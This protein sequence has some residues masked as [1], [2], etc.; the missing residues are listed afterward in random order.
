MH[1]LLLLVVLSSTGY[2][3][4]NV[5]ERA[6]DTSIRALR[7]AVREFVNDCGAPPTTE[8][9]LTAL[10]VDPGTPGWNGPYIPGAELHIL[11]DMWER[12]LSYEADGITFSIR[13][14][15]ADGTFGNEDD[16]DGSQRY[17]SPFPVVQLLFLGIVATA[18]LLILN[19][20]K[21]RTR[22]TGESEHNPGP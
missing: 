17:G 18:G 1:L 16:Q 14:A 20:A 12:Q 11:L 21:I 4:A 7:R 9:G 2:Q 10:Q 3:P 5:R 6:T 15:G 22:A 8:Q 13:S 19:K